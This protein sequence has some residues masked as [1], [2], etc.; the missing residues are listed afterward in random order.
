MLITGLQ[1]VN[2]IE[3]GLQNRCFAAKFAKVL[4]TPVFT[5]EF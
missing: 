4:R 2:F 5:P 3:K 1:S